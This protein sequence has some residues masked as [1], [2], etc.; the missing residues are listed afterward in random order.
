MKNIRLK[1]RVEKN[2]ILFFLAMAVGTISY[3]LYIMLHLFL[4]RFL[5]EIEKKFGTGNRSTCAFGKIQ[6]TAVAALLWDFIRSYSGT[7]GNN[8]LPFKK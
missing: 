6:Y 8:D 1:W 5:F 4:L 2:D 3:F 7:S